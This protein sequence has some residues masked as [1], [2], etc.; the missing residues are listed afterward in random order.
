MKNYA[1]IFIHVFVAFA[2]VFV[3]CGNSSTAPAKLQGNWKG[4]TGNT[5]LKITGKKFIMDNDEQNAEDYF[6]K[7]DSIFTSFEGNQ[8][9]TRFVIQKLDDHNLNLMF[10][11]SVMVEFTR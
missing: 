8:P 6:V 1:L 10:P 5:S 9:Y 11:D 7:A 4:K 2:L 3:A